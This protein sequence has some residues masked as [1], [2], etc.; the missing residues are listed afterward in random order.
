MNSFIEIMRNTPPILWTQILFMLTLS[1]EWNI[2][3]YYSFVFI[4]ENREKKKYI[5]CCRFSHELD[6]RI[7]I[8]CFTPMMQINGEKLPYNFRIEFMIEMIFSRNN[9]LNRKWVH[10]IET[11]HKV[12]QNYDVQASRGDEDERMS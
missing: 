8:K 9:S 4:S 3:I 5:T 6:S 7:F 10:L 1:K 2:F 12:F 11:L